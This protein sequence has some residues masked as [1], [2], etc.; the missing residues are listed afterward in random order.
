M[1]ISIAVCPACTRALE[2]LIVRDS[3]TLLW[4]CESCD[5]KVVAGGADSLLVNSENGTSAIFAAGAAEADEEKF[6]WDVQLLLSD[7]GEEA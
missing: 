3:I 6:L 2:S 4:K 5:K 7:C 1:L